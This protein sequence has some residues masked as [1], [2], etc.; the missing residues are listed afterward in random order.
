[1][2]A[3]RYNGSKYSNKYYYYYCCCYYYFTKNQYYYYITAVIIVLLLLVLAVVIFIIIIITITIIIIITSLSL[4]LSL[5]ILSLLS[6]S[7]LV[8]LLLD[9]ARVSYFQVHQ[10]PPLVLIERVVAARKSVRGFLQS[11]SH[12]LTRTCASSE[13]RGFSEWIAESRGDAG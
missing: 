11:L 3:I 4:S 10:Q 6:L 12:S 2:T 7:L 9:S 8:L 5:Y 1:M 13:E